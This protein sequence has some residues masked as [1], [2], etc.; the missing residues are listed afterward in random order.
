[1]LTES[2]LNGLLSKF[3]CNLEG[4][5]FF[6]SS[7]HPRSLSVLTPERQ[8]FR[9]GFTRYEQIRSYVECYMWTRV[10]LS[11]G[12]VRKPRRNPLHH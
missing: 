6:I 9:G 11:P 1:M 7:S 8:N 5:R 12:P 4:C 10:Q 3:V 2:V